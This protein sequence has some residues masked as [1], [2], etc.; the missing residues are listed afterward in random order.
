[1]ARQKQRHNICRSTASKETPRKMYEQGA[2]RCRQSV[3]NRPVPQSTALIPKAVDNLDIRL[4][5]I[6]TTVVRVAIKV[7]DNSQTPDADSISPE[8][9]KKLAIAGGMACIPNVTGCT[10]PYSPQLEPEWE[11]KEESVQRDLEEDY[12]EREEGMRPDIKKSLHVRL[13]TV[14]AL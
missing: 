4:E 12:R 9:Q 13:L 1:M 6:T 11:T 5:D 3:L 2:C 14:V 8:S 10:I 7:L